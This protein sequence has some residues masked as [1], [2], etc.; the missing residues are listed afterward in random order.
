MA[1][2]A[3]TGR[4]SQSGDLALEGSCT[5]LREFARALNRGPLSLDLFV[6][7]NATASPYEEFLRCIVI[8][9]SEER[10]QIAREGTSLVISGDDKSRSLCAENIQ[11]LAEPADAT[12]TRHLHVDYH[13]DHFYLV[14]QS[15]PLVIEVTPDVS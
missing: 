8:K 6:P 2:L 10:V 11:H 3:L 1:D 14:P 5:A 9:P 4:Y 12:R 13:P 15:L 7:R